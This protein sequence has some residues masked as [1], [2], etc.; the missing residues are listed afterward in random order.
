[1]TPLNVTLSAATVGSPPAP[2]HRLLA[3][4]L[5]SVILRP[6]SEH[7]TATEPEGGVSSANKVLYVPLTMNTEVSGKNV[8]DGLSSEKA[9]GKPGNKHK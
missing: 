8:R 4:P 7:F 3:L 1:M 2:A 9:A 6:S 5:T